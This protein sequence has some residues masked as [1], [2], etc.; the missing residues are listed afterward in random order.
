VSDTIAPTDSMYRSKKICVVSIV[1]AF[2]ALL[3]QKIL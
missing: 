1:S 2:A 3:T